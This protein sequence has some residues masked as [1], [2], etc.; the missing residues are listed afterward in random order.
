MDG[1]NA[2]IYDGGLAPVEQMNLS[3]GTMTYL[4]ADSLGSIRGTVSSSGALTGTASYDAWGNLSAA[5][6]LT[7]VTPFGYAGGYTDL[8]G[9]IYLLNRY[10]QPGAGQ[11][12][13]VDAAI[14]QTLQPYAY[15]D[16]NPVSNV[17][18]LGTCS[19]W[20]S[21]CW[22]YYA[23]LAAGYAMPPS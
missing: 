7:G 5:G 9:M 23:M 14:A 11:F 19:W 12:I 2:Y 22:K 17:D 15:A 13:W 20:S 18:P 1:A 8:D 21:R 4:V 3:S 6:G 10:Y 16:G